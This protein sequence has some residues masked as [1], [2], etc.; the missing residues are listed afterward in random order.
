MP[1]RGAFVA[2]ISIALAGGLF[3]PVIS[4]A[5]N[6]AG[7]TRQ[8]STAPMSDEG[9]LLR[10]AMGLLDTS[11]N[12]D[13]DAFV[14]TFNLSGY[15]TSRDRIPHLY[16]GAGDAFIQRARYFDARWGIGPFAELDLRNDWCIQPGFASA[17]TGVSAEDN[18]GI[19]W[20]G[21]GGSSET[22]RF[23]E[24]IRYKWEIPSGIAVIALV[25]PVR[26]SFGA[27]SCYHTLRMARRR[28]G[29]EDW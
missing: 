29:E 4:A 28:P 8:S 21:K 10:A 9:A 25:N 22:V 18:Y 5:N 11:K 12:F 27:S 26:G 24:G 2:A 17:I 1:V 15:N 14:A 20:I 16:S 3:L 19:G 7:D 23:Q 13:E 6:S